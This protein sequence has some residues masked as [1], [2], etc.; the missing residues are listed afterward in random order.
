MSHVLTVK[1]PHSLLHQLEGASRRQSKSKGALVREA[2]EK[3][4]KAGSAGNDQ[5][6]R[7]EWIRKATEAMLRGKKV[8]Y[9]RTVDWETIQKKAAAGAPHDMTPEEEVMAFRRRH[10]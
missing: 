4:L 5:K 2:I 3:W 7:Q 1:I 9:R 6:D 8:P 10:F